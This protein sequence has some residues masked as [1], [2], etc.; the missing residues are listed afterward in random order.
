MLARR[1]KEREKLMHQ[2]LV[3]GVTLFIGAIISVLIVAVVIK[4]FS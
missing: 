4:T 2:V 3:G 1:K